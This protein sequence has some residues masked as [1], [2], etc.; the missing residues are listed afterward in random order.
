MAVGMS[1]RFIGW[2]VLALCAAAGSDC[3]VGS[4]QSLP[5]STYCVSAD[6]CAA[7]CRRFVEGDKGPEDFI[8]RASF[9]LGP[10][11]SFKP[12]PPADP[13]APVVDPTNVYSEVR[14][15]NFSPA[16]ADALPRIYSPN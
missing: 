3:L 10:P 12:L 5:V 16:V 13:P 15:G 1:S 7:L 14:P 2:L 11:E 4:A 8:Q 6:Q 9:E